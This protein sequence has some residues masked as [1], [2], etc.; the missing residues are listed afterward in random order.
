MSQVW[1][2]T[3]FEPCHNSLLLDGS[4]RTRKLPPFTS[5]IL[6]LWYFSTWALWF[7]C[8]MREKHEAQ[9]I[10]KD[11]TDAHLIYVRANVCLNVCEI[12]QYGQMCHFV[13]RTGYALVKLLF[14]QQETKAVQS[15][16]A[17]WPNKWYGNI[18]G[19]LRL[20]RWGQTALTS[21]T[22]MSSRR[23]GGV[24]K[25]CGEWSQQNRYL[26]ISEKYMPVI[27]VAKEAYMNM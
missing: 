13:L 8:L 24:S 1:Q 16:G 26:C 22:K 5:A 7:S 12:P 6:S 10:P 27:A 14:P 18:V 25:D 3:E 23:G 21:F 15:R 19:G 9:W 4:E 20:E 11:T 17:H 2:T